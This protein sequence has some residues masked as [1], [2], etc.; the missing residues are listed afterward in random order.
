MLRAKI[1]DVNEGRG[2][3]PSVAIGPTVTITTITTTLVS[4][5]I[6]T[7]GPDPDIPIL[8]TSSPKV[9]CQIGR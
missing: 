8:E 9:G 3:G 6:I 1:R 5:P 2:P 7:C 4:H